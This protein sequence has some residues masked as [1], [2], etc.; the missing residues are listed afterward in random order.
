VYWT[1]QYHCDLHLQLPSVAW[2][3]SVGVGVGEEEPETT[4]TVM[5]NARFSLI[6]TRYT[7]FAYVKRNG[8]ATRR[9]DML[10]GE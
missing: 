5:Q 8:H 10:V 4:G 3:I 7:R 9:H 2:K 1:A 6:A